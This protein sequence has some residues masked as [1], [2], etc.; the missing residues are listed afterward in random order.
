MA[1]GLAVAD[2]PAASS[3][4]ASGERRQATIVFSD[5]SGYTALNT[6]VDPEEV[7]AVLANIKASA[8]TVI[9]RHGGTVNQFVGDE[10]MALFGVPVA[11]RDDARHAVA[12][13]LE[14]HR[15]VDDMAP[16]LQ[17]RLGRILSLHTGID[18]GL[19]VARRS[20][21]RGGAFTVTGDAV[22]TAARLRSA[23]ASGEVLV[24]HTTWQQVADFFHADVPTAVQVKGKE[25]ALWVHRV[26][27]ER[28]SRETAIKPIV[29]RDDELREFLAVAQTCRDRGKGRVVVVRGD[30][31]VGKSRLVSEFVHG[32]EARGYSCHAAVVL[33]FG[34]Q[35]GRD[36]VRSLTRSLLGL[37][38]GADEA[39]R[40]AAIEHAAAA[41]EIGPDRAVPLYDL[42]D[43]PPPPLQRALIAAMNVASRDTESLRTLCT[44]VIHESTQRPV[45]L[46][47]DDIHWADPWTLARLAALATVAKNH[48]LLLV[49]TTRFAGDPTSGAWRAALHGSPLISVDLGPLLPADAL[50][51]AAS[52]SPA[53]DAIRQLCV[54]RAEGNPL[55]LE[56]LL[57]NAGEMQQADLPGSIQAL[58][59][60]RL[61]RLDSAD[62]AALQAASVLGQRFGIASLRHVAADPACNCDVLIA[63]F[64]VRFDG[65]EFM[66]CHA[67]ICDG[68]YASLL[69][70]SRRQLHVRAAEWYVSHDAVLA[71]EHFERGNDA[72][73]PQAFL[74]ASN[75]AA[76][77]FRFEPA[78][79]LAERGLR[80][81]SQRPT[82]FAIQM[83]CAHWLIELGRA[84]EAVE[85][86]GAALPACEGLAERAQ[87]LILQAAGMRLNDRIDEGL[88]AL[89]EA[90]PLAEQAGLALELSHLHHLRGNLLFPLGR[91]AECLHAHE[92][93]L[94]HAIEA[95]S[96]EAQAAALGGL[97][98]AQYLHGRMAAAN[99]QFVKCVAL[100]RERGFG[101]LEVANLPMIG[102]TQLH[103]NE[104]RG[105]VELGHQ[106]I[107]LAMR[108]AQPRAEL[109]A[110]VMVVWIDGLIRC[111]A[112]AVSEPLDRALALAGSLRAKRFEGQ[113]YGCRALVALRS[114]QRG[115]ARMHA[116]NALGICREHGMGHT[117]PWILGVV[118]LVEIDPTARAAAIAEGEA[119]LLRGCVSHNHIFFRDM[120]IDAALESH[121]WSLVE[122]LCAKLEAYTAAQPLPFSDFL[123]TRGRALARLGREGCDAALLAELSRLRDQAVECELNCALPALNDALAAANAQ[124]PAQ[125]PH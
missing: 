100:A 21:T 1:C 49:M 32:A 16:A 82:R 50:R 47:V 122:S 113:L 77:Q 19:I 37:K 6:T 48:A 57:L 63:H 2:T 71:A 41:P 117:G 105:A 3:V 66:F 97:G 40:R 107:D 84:A 44:L 14:L 118:A 112:D 109:I 33:D 5:L 102:W 73:A 34:A 30:P 35:T 120:A 108:A 53:S 98:D 79:A 38:L 58:V 39:E 60:A 23:A 103:L 111:S 78:L 92:Q 75:A 10:V 116:E 125:G 42:V 74:V 91:P 67:L 80:L 106:A 124:L 55:F 85:L 95:G 83:A 65:D 99:E 12:A 72:R 94:A 89:Q 46:L 96:L 56:Q 76:A 114:G 90:Q 86:C 101:R 24:S 31:G 64:L 25:Q 20:D 9:E 13:A 104:L 28:S 62:K 29:G 52:A 18:T 110:R 27:A 4:L 11:R 36:A 88:A 45:L 59:H 22:N 121:D 93:A 26:Y 51:L 43:V 123:I 87:A 70:S 61:D 15:V 81:A 69:H 115:L 17:A 68:A 119:E 8:L 7:E 54:Q